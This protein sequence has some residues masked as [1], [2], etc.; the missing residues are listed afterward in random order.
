MQASGGN[1]TLMLPADLLSGFLL[2]PVL[3]DQ[4]EILDVDGAV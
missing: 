2:T 1:S 3:D 4:K